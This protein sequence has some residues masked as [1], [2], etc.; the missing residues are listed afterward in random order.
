MS[1]AIFIY[2]HDEVVWQSTTRRILSFTYE[3]AQNQF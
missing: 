3:P 2:V 1:V